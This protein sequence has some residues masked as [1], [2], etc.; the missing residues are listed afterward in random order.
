ML[1]T[2]R[3]TQIKECMCDR[4]AYLAHA[5]FA[6]TQHVTS[7]L[8]KPQALQQSSIGSVCLYLD[9]PGLTDTRNSFAYSMLA[10]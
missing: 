9:I 3:C 5:P 7:T 4:G 1:R 6:S 10:C 8:C 2:A